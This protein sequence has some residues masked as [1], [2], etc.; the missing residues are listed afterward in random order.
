MKRGRRPAGPE[1]VNRLDGSDIARERAKAVLET[2]AGMCGVDDA[3]QRLDICGQRFHQLR[4][5]I[6]EGV[7]MAAE[8]GRPG[9]R[10]QTPSEAEEKIRHLEQQ[11][12]ELQRE[13]QAS[14]AREEIALV[15]ARRGNGPEE[16]EKKTTSPPRRGRPPGMRKST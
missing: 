14:K 12:A 15:L 10:A 6:M 8:P 11:V 4:H 3:C 7:M 1:Y 16:P 2:V 5:E 13:L 9:R